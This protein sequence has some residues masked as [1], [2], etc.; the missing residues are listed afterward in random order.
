MLTP[1]GTKL[2]IFED[3]RI[4]N[5]LPKHLPPIEET[6]N[7]A[8]RYVINQANFGS[9]ELVSMTE[10][11]AEEEDHRLYLR[12]GRSF[13]LRSLRIAQEVTR[14]LSKMPKHSGRRLSLKT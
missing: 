5:Q 2:L 6:G 3:F 9:I 10:E 4:D 1:D 11:D 14:K 13:Q 12:S 8:A 7:D